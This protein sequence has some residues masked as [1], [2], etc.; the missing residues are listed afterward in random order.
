M[1][2]RN[3]HRPN[4]PSPDDLDPHVVEA[5]LGSLRHPSRSPDVTARVMSRLGYEPVS[6]RRARHWRWMVAARRGGFTALLLLAVV[7]GVR[8]HLHSDDARRP[9]EITV[10]DAVHS[11]VQQKREKFEGFLRT[12]RT[13]SPRSAPVTEPPQ[14][15]ATVDPQAVA[16]YGWV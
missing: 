7:V 5:M 4:S 12:I 11:A 15:D 8:L 13:L 14:P 1:I 16:P 6:P 10:P 3:D 2:D 9:A